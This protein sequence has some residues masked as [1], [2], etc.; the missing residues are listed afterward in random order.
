M[1]SPLEALNGHGSQ[2]KKNA[3][4]E[5]LSSTLPASWYSTKSI[6][7]LERRAIFSR[8]W[9]LVSHE[10]RFGGIGSYASY[11]IAGF[12]VLIIRDREATLNAYLNV[13]RHRAFP[14]VLQ[15]EGTAN[16]LHCKYHGE[17]NSCAS[18]LHCR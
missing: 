3:A 2:D 9:L 4:V 17:L 10:L 14:V 18:S 13:C 7:D 6:F 11:T 5:A 12:P 8:H 16:I 15:D 1:N